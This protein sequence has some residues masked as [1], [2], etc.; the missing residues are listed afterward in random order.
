MRLEKL[1]VIST[2][3]MHNQFH[4]LQPHML[5]GG[6]AGLKGTV[7]LKSTIS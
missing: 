6:R 1:F 5:A 2:Q 7:L 4:T 3:T